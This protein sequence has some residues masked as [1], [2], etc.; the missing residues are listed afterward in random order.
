MIIVKEQGI[1]YYKDGCCQNGKRFAFRQ[2]E[3]I[4]R[5]SR[6]SGGD[7]Y[8]ENKNERKK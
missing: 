7:T 8:V 4:L 1:W 3:Y 6:I 5:T 2:N